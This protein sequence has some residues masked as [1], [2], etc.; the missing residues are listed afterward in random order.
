[1]RAA[2]ASLMV[3]FV[4]ATAAHFGHHHDPASERTTAHHICGFCVGLGSAADAPREHVGALRVPASHAVLAFTTQ[5]P[6]GGIIRISARPR[7]PPLR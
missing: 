3:V 1:M 4:L 7:A 5:P 2:L 6:V